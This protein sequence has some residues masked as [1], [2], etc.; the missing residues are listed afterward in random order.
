MKPYVLPPV[1]RPSRDAYY[2]ELARV[3]STRADCLRRHVGA[4]LVKDDHIISTGYNGTPR[5]TRHCSEGGC[6]RCASSAQSGLNLGQC[7]CVH[8]EVNA[9]VLAAKYGVSADGAMLYTTLHPC[10]DCTKLL[11]QAGVAVVYYEQYYP[12]SGGTRNQHAYQR[13]VNESGLI[14]CQLEV[15]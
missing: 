8:A 7:L 4:V 9:V 1:T 5:H 15:E 14:V 2:L 12:L 11:I 13:M 3:A 10:I 6:P